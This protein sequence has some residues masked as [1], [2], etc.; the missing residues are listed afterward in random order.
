MDFNTN[1]YSEKPVKS[2]LHQK[3]CSHKIQKDTAVNG[4]RGMGS[5]QEKHTVDVSSCTGVG[6]AQ[7]STHKIQKESLLP[8][9]VKN[10]QGMEILLCSAS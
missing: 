3:L 10:K 7:V 2:D 5:E 4:Y 9:P 6:H 8:S 1:S